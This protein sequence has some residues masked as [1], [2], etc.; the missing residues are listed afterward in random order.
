MM[1]LW[2]P[3]TEANMVLVMAYTLWWSLLLWCISIV[4][5]VRWW[6]ACVVPSGV[7]LLAGLQVGLL[8]LVLWL[9]AS[10][11]LSIPDQD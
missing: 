2:Q 9:S 5:S 8:S 4:G 10:A 11:L 1:F 6:R 3:I 7:F